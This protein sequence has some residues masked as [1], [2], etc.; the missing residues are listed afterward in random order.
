MHQLSTWT[1]HVGLLIMIHGTGGDS[2]SPICRY[3][4]VHD[5]AA[6]ANRMEH[7]F[8]RSVAIEIRHRA[9]E[10]HNALS[11][12]DVGPLHSILAGLPDNGHHI[13]QDQNKNRPAR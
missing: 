3:Q 6:I 1:T 4:V 10:P 12:D 5:G 13:D 8:L 7:T 9:F 2:S 11:R